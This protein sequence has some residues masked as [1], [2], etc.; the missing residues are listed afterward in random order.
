MKKRAF[1][2]IFNPACTSSARA[3]NMM[4]CA[5]VDD[6]RFHD[7]DIHGS[8]TIIDP[9]SYMKIPEETSKQ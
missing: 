2:D 6:C 5:T 8:S 3:R 7:G 1:T 4:K 9:S